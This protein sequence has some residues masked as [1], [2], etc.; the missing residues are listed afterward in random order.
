[1]PHYICHGECHG[2]SPTP[3]VC[4]TEAC[5]KKAQALDECVCADGTHRTGEK[6]GH[7]GKSTVGYKCEMCGAEDHSKDLGH[8]CGIDHLKLKCSNCNQPESKCVC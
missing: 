1:M 2:V 5:S 7:C 8:P 6:C 3:G 4:Q